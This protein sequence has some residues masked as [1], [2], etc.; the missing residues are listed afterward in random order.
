MFGTRNYISETPLSS[1]TKLSLSRSLFLELE[2]GT[3]ICQKLLAVN[4][5]INVK[6][7]E[8]QLPR[9]QNEERGEVNMRPG[10]RIAI[11]HYC[12]ETD[13]KR[14]AKILVLTAPQ[15]FLP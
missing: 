2:L 6:R 13:V 10:A 12:L 14:F 9:V 4:L 15:V 7:H 5:G 3:L 1:K 8:L 11:Q